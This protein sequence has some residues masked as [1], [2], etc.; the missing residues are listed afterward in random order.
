MFGM[1]EPKTNSNS[2]GLHVN[3]H[4]SNHQVQ[5]VEIQI[6]TLVEIFKDELSG[7]QLKELKEIQDSNDT[8]EVKKKLFFEKLKS[9][10][11]DVTAGILSGILANPDFLQQLTS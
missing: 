8:P 6:S 10:G 4:Q 5:Q 11:T 2:K 3:I 7:K 1:D 9:F